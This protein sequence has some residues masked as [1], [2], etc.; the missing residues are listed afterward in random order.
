MNRNSLTNWLS[1]N[2]I[3]WSQN[4]SEAGFE[5]SHICPRFHEKIVSKIVICKR[6]RIQMIDTEIHALPL[7]YYHH[8]RPRADLSKKL[9]K[10]CKGGRFGLLK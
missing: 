1:P 6:F 8:T 5:L 7:I 10:S 4:S 9:F 3:Q 2:T